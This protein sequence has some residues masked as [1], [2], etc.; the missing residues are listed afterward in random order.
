MGVTK[1]F[2]WGMGEGVLGGRGNIVV[3]GGGVT[4]MH[5][6]GCIKKKLTKLNTRNK[7]LKKKLKV[8]QQF[9]C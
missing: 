1:L 7:Q 9:K 4:P 6:T 3:G 5:T 2:C 8:F